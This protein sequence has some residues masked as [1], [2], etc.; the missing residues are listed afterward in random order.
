M[1]A[2]GQDPI[3]DFPQLFSISRLNVYKAVLRQPA[4]TSN[5]PLH[6]K[7]LRKLALRITPDEAVVEN[8]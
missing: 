7:S 2:T 5:L 6:I 3:R 8:L 4:Y 1:D